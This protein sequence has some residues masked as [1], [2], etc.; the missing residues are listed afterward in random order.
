MKFFKRVEKKLWH[1]RESASTSAEHQEQEE[2]TSAG[3]YIT[4]KSILHAPQS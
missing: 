2:S 3:D 4:F 1:Q